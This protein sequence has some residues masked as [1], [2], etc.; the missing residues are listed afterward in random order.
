[1]LNRL[2]ILVNIILRCPVEES[3]SGSPLSSETSETS[4]AV[5]GLSDM[6]REIAFW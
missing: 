2:N 5:F 1:M 3:K 6:V 4:L